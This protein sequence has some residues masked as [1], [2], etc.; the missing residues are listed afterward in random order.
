MSGML[1]AMCDICMCDML[2]AMCV[3]YMSDMLPGMYGMCE[4]P[5]P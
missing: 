4:V 1:R 2:R 5:N 3:M